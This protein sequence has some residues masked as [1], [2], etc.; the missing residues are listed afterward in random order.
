[1]ARYN[2]INTTGSVAQGSNITTPYSGLL[3]TITTGSGVVT[4][5]NPVLYSGAVQTFYNST[6]GNVTLQTP[7]GVFNGPGTSGSAS[8]TLPAASIITVI[9]DGTNYLAQ[10]WLGGPATHT[11]ITASSTITANSAVAFNPANANISIQPT[12]T[13]TVTINPTAVGSISNMSGSF[14]SLSV[15]GATT[16]T[17]LGA[18]TSYN[19]AGASLLVSGG[20][21]IA[22]AVYTNNGLYVAKNYSGLGAGNALATFYGTDSGVS[23]TGISITTKGSTSLYDTGSYPLQ[24]WVNGTAIASFRGDGN[25]GIGTTSPSDLFTI[26]NNS[27]SSTAGLTL[28]SS[29]TNDA[30]IYSN[31]SNLVFNSLR[32]NPIYWQIN[33]STQLTLN[34][35]GYLG[36]G[37]TTPNSQLTVASTTATIQ[38]QPLNYGQ[39]QYASYFAT[40]ANAQA[41]LQ[42]GNN[43]TNWIVGGNS[44]TGGQ[45]TFIV[46]NT[47][48]APAT[49]NGTTALTLSSNG[50]GNFPVGLQLAG[51]QVLSSSNYTSY[52][53][54]LVTY[55][56]GQ[57]YPSGRSMFTSNVSSFASYPGGSGSPT[58]YDYCLEVGNG[59]R[60]W[61]MSVDWVSAPTPYIRTLRDCCQNW[62]SWYSFSVA[63]A[64]DRRRKTNI[65]PVTDHR[66]IIFGLNATRYDVVNEDGTIGAVS[67][68]DPDLRV[69]RPKEIGYIAQDAIKVVPEVVKFNPRQDTPNEVGWANAY[70]VDYERLVPVLTEATKEIYTDM[71][72]VKDMMTAMQAQIAA[73][74]AEIAALKGNTN[75]S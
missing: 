31:G 47:N 17:S 3:T 70:T 57:T 45:L 9:S 19:S 74:Q 7:S 30:R 72:A 13:G 24:V 60:G 5:P 36:V 1:M 52:V 69:E 39:S 40:Q 6:A 18:A 11:T 61:E 33:G 23:N 41:M 20:V 27:A 43:G 15:S 2:S 56:T 22:G 49:P 48:A 44:N 53:Q 73:L 65:E 58:S 16:L 64:S 71:D 55:N 12:G 62:S 28:A 46:N 51:N 67:D 32:T 8:L 25:V 42:L 59:S 34:G 63:A 26:D 66:Q 10:D 4:L 50:V 21:G 75:G 38:V 29:G 68:E 54:Q 35:S 14:T 37:T